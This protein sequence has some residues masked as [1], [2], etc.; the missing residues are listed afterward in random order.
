VSDDD[1]FDLWWGTQ[2]L[3][4][5]YTDDDKASALE[6]WRAAMLLRTPNDEKLRTLRRILANAEAEGWQH[7]PIGTIRSVLGPDKEH[8]T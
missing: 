8:P 6:G 3:I 7:L 2:C 4:D 5:A 1:E